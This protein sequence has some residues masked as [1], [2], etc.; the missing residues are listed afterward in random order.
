MT[1]V[2]SIVT[3][4]KLKVRNS[5]IMDGIYSIIELEISLAL[6]SNVPR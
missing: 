4:P 2:A 6:S 5:Q 1:A 3:R